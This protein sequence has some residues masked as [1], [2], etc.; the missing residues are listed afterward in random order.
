MRPPSAIRIRG[1]AAA[2]ACCTALGAFSWEPVPCCVT[3]FVPS[4][5]LAGG[6]S[7]GVRAPGHPTYHGRLAFV[8]DW[9]KTQG[10]RRRGWR[11]WGQCWGRGRGRQG[12]EGGGQGLAGALER[13]VERVGLGDNGLLAL[14]DRGL[15]RT[16]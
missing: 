8:G 3:R 13:T 10:S 6:S 14:P 4:S 1:R 5:F 12:G 15:A 9:S 7:P 16:E 2:A 11:C